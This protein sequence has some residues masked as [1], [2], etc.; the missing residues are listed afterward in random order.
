MKGGYR[1]YLNQGSGKQIQAVSNQEALSYI[2]NEASVFSLNSI[3]EGASVLLSR[4]Q[5]MERYSEVYNQVPEV[6]EHQGGDDIAAVI[7]F[8][9]VPRFINADKGVKDASLRTSYYTGKTFSNASQGT[10]ISM[11]YF[12]D[13]YIDFGLYIMFIPLMLIYLAIGYVYAKIITTRKF[14]ILFVYGLLIGFFLSMG[15]F[16]SDSLFFLG[17]FRNNIAFVVLCYFVLFTPLH[18]LFVNKQ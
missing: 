9:L 10:S 13:L 3:R 12:C 2:F 15:A 6:I 1:S 18:K 4:V 16:E 11:G 8:L 7:E 14:N 5:Y 17:K